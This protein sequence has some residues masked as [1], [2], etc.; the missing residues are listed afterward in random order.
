MDTA[1]CNAMNNRFRKSF[2]HLQPQP[3]K[4]YVVFGTKLGDLFDK[5]IILAKANAGEKVCDLMILG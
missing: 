1:V 5:W 3:G 2:R 4:S